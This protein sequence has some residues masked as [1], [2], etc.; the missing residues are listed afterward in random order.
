VRVDAHNRMLA[1]AHAEELPGPQRRL[2]PV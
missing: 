1:D 2:R